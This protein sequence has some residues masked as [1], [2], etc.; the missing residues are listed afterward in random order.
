MMKL[1]DTSSWVSSLRKKGDE[2]VRARVRDLVLT[3]QAAWC[4]AVRLE[5]WAGVGTDPERRMLRQMEQRIPELAITD[6]VWQA[7][8]DLAERCRS[9]GFTV[10]ATDLLVATCARHHGVEIEA[11]DA[12]FD[13]LR[14][15]A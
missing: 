11:A 9:V 4:A 1:V 3:G 12:H 13:R 15:I 7:A 2:T 8:C 5:L 6:E 10:P 14:D